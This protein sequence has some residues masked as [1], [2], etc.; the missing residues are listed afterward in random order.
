MN[1]QCRSEKRCKYHTRIFHSSHNPTQTAW[2]TFRYLYGSRW[3]HK[4]GVRHVISARIWRVWRIHWSEI[5]AFSTWAMNLPFFLIQ[6]RQGKWQWWRTR[7][8]LSVMVVVDWDRTCSQRRPSTVMSVL[9]PPSRMNY[10][11]IWT[12]QLVCPGPQYSPHVSVVH[13]QHWAEIGWHK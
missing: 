12:D 1:H 8:W 10:F 5:C 9:C 4:S 3:P 13:V 11:I 6:G 7:V 2:T